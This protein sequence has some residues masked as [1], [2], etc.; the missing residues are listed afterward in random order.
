MSISEKDLR[1]IALGVTVV[2]VA[3]LFLIFRMQLEYKWQH[4]KA[5]SGDMDRIEKI[6]KKQK[7]SELLD[8]SH[9]LSFLT[10][11]CNFKEADT[12]YQG[13]DAIAQCISFRNEIIDSQRKALLWGL[14]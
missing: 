6:M 2:C 9:N 10:S 4:E 14:N 11:E 7:A 13:M 8:F 12:V 3:V 1:T 5:V